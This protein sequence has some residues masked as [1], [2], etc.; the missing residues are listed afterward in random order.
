M[1]L[2]IVEA[3]VERPNLGLKFQ[4]KR[5]PTLGTTR[6][7]IGMSKI[8]GNPFSIVKRRI[9]PLV[10]INLVIGTNGLNNGNTNG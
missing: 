3:L 5:K 6:I 7:P 9:C 4:P 2:V 8:G 10:K 1:L